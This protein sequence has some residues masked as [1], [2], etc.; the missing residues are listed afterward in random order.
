MAAAN[1][2]TSFSMAQSPRWLGAFAKCAPRCNASCIKAVW[3][4]AWPSPNQAALTRLQWRCA[5]CGIGKDRHGD[6]EKDGAER[7]AVID[8]R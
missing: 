7:P 1:I 4:A 8:P 5:R 3:L 6:F 2:S